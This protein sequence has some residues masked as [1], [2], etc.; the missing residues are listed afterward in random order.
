MKQNF[1]QNTDVDVK[2]KIINV[3]TELIR[4]SNG[5]LNHVTIRD[6]AYRA[7][8]SIG[9]IN[10]HFKSKKAL[11]EICVGRIIEQVIYSFEFNQKTSDEP[12]DRLISGSTDVF[13][14][15]KENPEIAKIS[16]I[17]DLTSPHMNTNSVNSY[18]GILNTIPDRFSE[19]KRRVIAFMLLSTIQSAFLI[20]NIASDLL[21][22]DLY[23]D[24]GAHS[25]FKYVIDLLFTTKLIN[26]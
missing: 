3:T 11:I 19:E 12:K 5:N 15:L 9:L 6:I 18:Q 1:N 17:S 7:D 25:F 13:A 26:D 22:F 16:I 20:R 23:T 21:S 8:V 2:G 24:E 10:Y 14:F 4:E